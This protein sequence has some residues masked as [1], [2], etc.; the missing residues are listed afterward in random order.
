MDLRKPAGGYN[1][2]DANCKTPGGAPIV[3]SWSHSNMAIAAGIAFSR[4]LKEYL[5]CIP[6]DSLNMQGRPN[7]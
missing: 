3:D 5:A 2:C 4:Q 6:A 1:Q 7:G